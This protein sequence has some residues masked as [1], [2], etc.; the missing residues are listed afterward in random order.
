MDAVHQSVE[1]FNGG[2]SK[3]LEIGPILKRCKSLRT[4]ASGFRYRQEVNKTT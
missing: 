3:W 4:R 1:E 2:T